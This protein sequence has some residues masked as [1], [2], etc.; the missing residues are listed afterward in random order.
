MAIA[1]RASQRATNSTPSGAAT[2]DITLPLSVTAGDLITVKGGVWQTSLPTI[3]VARQSGATIGAVTV[4][5]GSSGAFYASGYGVPFL[6]YAVASGSGTLTLRVSTNVGSGNYYNIC[7]DAFSGNAITLDV[8]GGES[9]GAAGTDPLDSITTL[10]SGALLISAVIAGGYADGWGVGSG[11]TKIADDIASTVQAYAAAFKI[12]G[13]PGA[14][15]V[16]WDL[17]DNTRAWSMVSVALK[18]TTAA[19]IVRQAMH[20]RRMRS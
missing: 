2:C 13:A 12:A 15:T 6:A 11:Y 18:E 16:D 17:V 5:Q 7:C 8:D 20:A 10:T 4:K 1:E 3:S 14:Y 19:T 9:T